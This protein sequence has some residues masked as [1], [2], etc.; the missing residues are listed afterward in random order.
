[1]SLYNPDYIDDKECREARRIEKEIIDEFNWRID[2]EKQETK[3]LILRIQD[4]V[5]VIST[6]TKGAAND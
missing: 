4:L 3:D 1:M 2:R 6:H 5:D